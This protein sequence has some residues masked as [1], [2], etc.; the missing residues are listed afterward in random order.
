MPGGD[1]WQVT[2]T[3]GESRPIFADTTS[4]VSL[5][6]GE[7]IA[8]YN[9]QPGAV[10]FIGARDNGTI[11]LQRIGLG[12][13]SAFL[14]GLPGSA[15]TTPAATIPVKILVD[16][17]E[18]TRRSVWEATLRK[19][20]EAASKI[21]HRHAMVKLNVVA[22]DTWDSN[23]TENNFTNSLNE[24]E[25]EVDPFPGQLA[26]G[27]SSQYEIKKGRIH[28]GG[29]H[30]ALRPHILLREWSH[31][32]TENE[33][34]ELLLHELGHYLGAAH[35]PEPDSAMR[36]VLGDGQARRAG[37]VIRYDPV[38]TLIM[39]MVGEE[40]RRRRVESFEEMA[41]ATQRRLKSIYKILGYAKPEDPAAGV[42]SRQ[43]RARRDDDPT[44]A[45]TRKVLSEMTQF[46]RTNQSL[47]P[48][49]SGR[50]GPWRVEGEELFNQ[51]VRSAAK[52]ATEV[53]EEQQVKSFLMGIGIGIG[54]PQEQSRRLTAIDRLVNIIDTPADRSIRKSYIGQPTVQ[55]RNDLARHFSV[56]AMLVASGGKD[57]AEAI[58]MAKELVDSNRGTGFSFADLAADKSG[59][60]LAQQLMDGKLKLSDVANNFEAKNYIVSVAGF[61]EGMT[62]MQ[63]IQQFGGQ[64][65]DR[66]KQM[67]ERIETGIQGLPAYKAGAKP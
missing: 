7:A 9:L 20:V 32:S 58:S 31:L 46:A 35:S 60:Y 1:P 34:L 38:N 12:D 54:D 33:K 64:N 41:P 5:N 66:F 29:T 24:F 4:T 23:D 10:Y 37:Y 45:A 16:D 3:P 8:Q 59:I 2:L 61:P 21:L 26:I 36:P 22:V 13:D 55:K 44:T 25:E 49:D 14:A 67:Q 52:A 43:L 47:Y 17:E 6:T 28:M 48:A 15:A 42:L 56:A 19:R 40:V 11:D 63:F 65:D 62:T 39:S 50:P 30:G 51:L 18:I 27:F 57:S 53:P